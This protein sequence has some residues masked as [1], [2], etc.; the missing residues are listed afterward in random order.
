MIYNDFNGEKISALGL[1][2]MRFPVKEDKS[3][4][5]E[6][7]REML[8]LSMSSGI[9][10]YDTAWVYHGGESE[11]VMGELLS[12][13][14][15]ESYHL[16]TKFPGFDEKSFCNVDGIFNEQLR[17]CRVEY[18]D[19]YLFHSVTEDNIES[20]L[21]PKYGVFD[22]LVRQKREGRIRHL[23][24]ST[25]GTLATMKRFLDA[26]GSELEF[27]QIQLNWLDWIFQDAK[28][29]VE[30][31]KSYGLPVFVMEPVRGGKLVSIDEKYEE[32][33][34]SLAKDRTLA[35]WAFRFIQGIPEVG[36]TLSGMS[37][38]AQLA[39]NIETFKEK[40][41]LSEQELSVL[42]QI[43]EQMSSA[44][45]VP[46]TACRYC[47][48]DCPMKLDI[49]WLIEIYNELGVL[50]RNANAK[51]RLA[52]EPKDKLPSAC[53]G[54]RACESVCPQ[55]IKISE[56]MARFAKCIG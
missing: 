27:C 51:L 34:R 17:K 9:N 53:I 55:G 52:E 32:R 43:S 50:G 2:C 14:P 47:T 4:D 49:P 7:V 38:L 26:Y 8:A 1:G 37:N 3:I 21:D 46:C 29:K 23:G 44:K 10:Y 30:L 28:A 16:A 45:S 11:S 20:Y 39:E 48:E 35:E 40:K 22:Y 31:V 54:C 13:Y 19:F 12:E 33:L 24:F 42:M 56:I 5:K 18:F 36:V 6:Q 41:P 15:R 25:H